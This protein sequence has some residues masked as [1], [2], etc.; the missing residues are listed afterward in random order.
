MTEDW[1]VNLV[2]ELTVRDRIEEGRYEP[3]SFE[4]NALHQVTA[5]E[6]TAP[7]SYTWDVTGNIETRTGGPYG[8]AVFMHD[9]RDR[10]TGVQQGSETTRIVLDPL[11]RMVGKVRH[12][13]AGDIA[14]AYLHDGDQVV[15]EYVQPAGGTGWQP[16]RRHLWARWIDD[17][18]V[19]QVDTDGDGTLETILY[20]ITDLL[21]SVQLLTDD[22]GAIAERITYDPDGTPH[23]WSADTVR[24]GVTRIAWTGDGTLPT[25]GTVT[26][27]A[28]EIGLSE[29]IDPASTTNATA[30]LTPDGGAAMTLTLTLAADRRTVYLTG[31]TVQ[32]GTPYTLHID[33]LTDTTG[34]TL[35]PEDATLT[36][37]DTDTYEILADTRP[38]RLL[39]VLD[40]ADALYLL[41]D[42]PVRASAGHDLS[43]ALT[44]TRQGQQVEGETTRLGAGVLRWQTVGDATLLPGATYTLTLTNLTDLAGNAASAGVTFTHLTTTNQMLRLAY[45]APTDS[46]PRPQSD[47][48]LTTLFQ[49]RTWHADLGMYHYRARW[50]LPEAGVFGERDPVGYAQTPN[51]YGYMDEDPANLLD[52]MGRQ[53]GA[54]G[55][56]NSEPENKELWRKY[57]SGENRDDGRLTV[58]IVAEAW[59]VATKIGPGYYEDFGGKGIHVGYNYQLWRRRDGTILRGLFFFD[60]VTAVRQRKLHGD[61]LSLPFGPWGIIGEGASVGVSGNVAWFIGATTPGGYQDLSDDDILRFWMGEFRSVGAA[62]PGGSGSAFWSKS[63][64]GLE[65][66]GGRAGIGFGGMASITYYDATTLS[67]EYSRIKADLI[68]I[69]SAGNRTAR[70]IVERMKLLSIQ[71]LEDAKRYLRELFTSRSPEEEGR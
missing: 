48:G 40:G 34:N 8:D 52:P 15:V 27:E 50:Y 24:P 41:L 59:G 6:G 23:F 65:L 61:Q 16:E 37:A 29:P 56:F 5:R 51:L 4:H 66:S 7:A 64:W 35:W 60:N 36:I 3:V 20:P 28:F 71:R 22:T 70:N 55:G 42:E 39:A 21:G 2:D 63:Y 67:A 10:L 53:F 19:E 11:G 26:A 12:T 38:P 44:L 46:Q 18:A 33:G 25:G 68:E 32:A 54:Y 58:G 43:D 31:A 69:A 1:R 49:G 17:L 14:H 57:S 45:T 30:T 13:A 9:W 62:F 47:Y